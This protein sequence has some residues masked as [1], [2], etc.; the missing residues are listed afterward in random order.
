MA[1]LKTRPRSGSVRAWI[2]TFEDPAL[3]RDMRELARM[4][5]Q[6]T[7]CP[8]RRWGERI[9]GFGSYH[10]TY[11]SGREGDWMITGFAPGAAQLSI[12]IMPGFAAYADLMA[13]L[14]RYKT[15]RSCLYVRRLDDVDRA[16]LEQLVTRSV[17]DM[18]RLYP[19]RRG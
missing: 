10:Y 15:G 14:G 16:I 13:G 7:G 1:E 3:R 12:Y 6:V 11:A 2:A 18:R 9:V 4:M 17:A 19:C 8:A 5:R